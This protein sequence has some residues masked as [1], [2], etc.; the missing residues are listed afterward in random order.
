MR[1][2][3]VLVR[4]EGARPHRR[5]HLAVAVATLAILASA[6]GMYDATPAPPG[7]PSYPPDGIKSTL[8]NQTNVDR[9]G[10]GLPALWWNA[11]LA[12][13]AQ[14]WSDYMAGSGQFRHRDLGAL[15]RSPGFEDYASLAENIL[16]GP[17]NMDANTI[18][19]S[20]MNSPGHRANL[21]GDFDAIGIGIS[22]GADGRLWAT[23]NF[24]RHF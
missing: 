20:W 17:G 18:H 9:A 23:E 3:K 15:I 8:Q 24:G 5:R 7:C 2:V 13:V 10:V 21:L 6:C 1:G 16:V 12:C 19:Q 14:E 11:R 22:R 4:R